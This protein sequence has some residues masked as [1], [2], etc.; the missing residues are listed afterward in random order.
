MISEYLSVRNKYY[1]N[2]FDWAMGTIDLIMKNSTCSGNASQI[3]FMLDAP[4]D[5]AHVRDSLGRFLRL[6]PVIH[7]RVSRHWTLTPYWKM[8]D[9]DEGHP[10][11]LTVTRLDASSQHGGL[12]SVL[13]A[14]VNRPFESEHHHLMFHLVYGEGE[15]C[16]ALTFDHR[17]FDA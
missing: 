15:Q 11:P 5:E 13:A 3:V 12:L 4:P 9:D 8:P 16:F 6:F 7:G 17:L 10:L 14:H 1:L 2:G